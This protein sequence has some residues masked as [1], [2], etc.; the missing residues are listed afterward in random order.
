MCLVQAIG[1]NIMTA[2]PISDL[3]P[4]LMAA[5][6][7]LTLRSKDSGERRV[8]L[9]HTFFTGYRRT[10]V[11]PREVL[12]NIS[13]PFT[14]QNEYFFGYKQARRREDDI[15]IVNAGC[16]VVFQPNSIEVLRLDLAF[17]GM[18]PTTVLALDTMKMAPQV[19]H[20]FIKLNSSLKP[21]LKTPLWL[22][23]GLVVLLLHPLAILCL[24]LK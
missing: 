14:Q 4:L 16:R 13:I 8:T 1:G 5:D 23:K 12:I 10:V 22:M 15:A 9:D 6:T 3:N 11:Q 24:L 2:S 17:G 18:A 7:F 21:L 20:L 19:S